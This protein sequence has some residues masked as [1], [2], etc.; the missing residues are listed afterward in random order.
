MLDDDDKFEL[1]ELF[2]TS[3]KTNGHKVLF[4]RPTISI[5][6]SNIY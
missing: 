5:I 2:Y 3:T 4:C 6:T 1:N